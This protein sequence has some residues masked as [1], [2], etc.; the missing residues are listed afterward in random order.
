MKIIITLSVLLSGIATSTVAYPK[1]GET[2]KVLPNI[3]LGSRQEHTTVA[4]GTD[5]YILGGLVPP[6]DSAVDPTS[7]IVQSY[8]IAHNTWS[9][10]TPMPR[11]LNHLNAAVVNGKI[12]V[13]GGLAV[14][15]GAWPNW[16]AAGD[17]WVYS[18]RQK[19]WEILAN[20][21]NGTERGSAAVGVY[22][23]TI[24]LAGGL[25]RLGISGQTT[26]TTVNAYCTRTN[27][28]STLE[29][30]PEK[31]DHAGS[32]VVGRIFYV[33]GGRINGEPS[34]MRDTV[35]AFDVSV[36]KGSWSTRAGKM[37]TARGGL[38]ASAVGHT[39][40][41]FGGEGNVATSTGVFNQTE[42]YNTKTDTWT[43]LKP[44]VLPRHGTSAAAVG[45]RVYIPGGGIQQQLGGTDYFDVF[46]L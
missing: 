2:W 31:R 34:G 45:G 21:P 33:V 35:L 15:P 22:G 1:P 29:S 46:K 18:P 43:S 40:Y 19:I 23:D 6:V 16:L 25:T 27:T 11:A 10:E 24:Y 44:M 8:S 37:P 7:N 9:S 4:L 32:A 5:V 14:G 39:I 26:V 3:T 13:L 17:C 42:A 30:L 41:A 12:Y 36:E 38:S 28:W 20:M